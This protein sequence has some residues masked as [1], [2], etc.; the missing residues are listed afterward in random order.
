MDVMNTAPNILAK[1]ENFE[2]L[3]DS[4]ADERAMIPTTLTS[5]CHW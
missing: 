1:N 3:R 4:F 5:F 2:R